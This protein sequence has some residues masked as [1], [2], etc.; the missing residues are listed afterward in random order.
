MLREVNGAALMRIEET[1]MFQRPYLDTWNTKAAALIENITRLLSSADTAGKHVVFLGDDD[2]RYSLPTLIRVFA[3]NGCVNVTKEYLHRPGSDEAALDAVEAAGTPYF[4][5]G[6]TGR[7]AGAGEASPSL[8]RRINSGQNKKGR[9]IAVVLLQPGDEEGLDFKWGLYAHCFAGQFNESRLIQFKGR[10]QRMC[11]R[12]DDK[13]VHY[14]EYHAVL[15]QHTLRMLEALLEA[16][17]PGE[18]GSSAAAAAAASRRRLLVEPSDQAML[19]RELQYWQRYCEFLDREILRLKTIMQMNGL[20]EKS[21]TQPG[22]HE[23]FWPMVRGTGPEALGPKAIVKR[24]KQ[25]AKSKKPARRMSGG[26]GESLPPSGTTWQGPVTVQQLLT[27]METQDHE[28]PIRPPSMSAAVSSAGSAEAS[29]H[30]G[31]F[32]SGLRSKFSNAFQGLVDRVKAWAPGSKAQPPAAGPSSQQGAGPDEVLTPEVLARRWQAQPRLASLTGTDILVGTFRPSSGATA[33][34]ALRRM[35]G[36]QVSSIVHDKAKELAQWS[37]SVRDAY[38]QHE[39]TR[40]AIESAVSG[41]K[42]TLTRA[43][44]DARTQPDTYKAIM[45][46]T[47]AAYKDLLSAA[48]TAWTMQRDLQAH[49]VQLGETAEQVL[50]D[51]MAFYNAP[52]HVMELFVPSEAAGVDKNLAAAAVGNWGVTPD[53]AAEPA[54][55]AQDL[56]GGK[57]KALWSKAMLQQ[58]KDLIN[59][60]HASPEYKAFLQQW[61]ARYSP[62]VY[63]THLRKTL[64]G[65][66]QDVLDVLRAAAV[67]CEALSAF[68][69]SLGYPATCDA[70][71]T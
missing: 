71:A 65:S 58:L 39:Y 31:G 6:V 70:A 28:T 63:F 3:A 33:A 53:L 41:M 40:E 25:P 24:R 5:F 54:R 60:M 44:T 4:N 66:L 51:Q 1:R 32:L 50:Q 16:R 55:D 10:F 7:A 56:F 30:G 13:K 46:T 14:F 21:P 68:H 34:T 26:A 15:G 35:M 18:A 38:T 11:A 67:D 23:V 9:V 48:H 49:I 47:V 61:D 43:R 59:L 2:K 36:L 57:T 62:D 45:K 19:N 52:E 22:R 64:F 12:G 69:A 29:L 17:F 20:Q 42:K 8:M 37:R 27:T